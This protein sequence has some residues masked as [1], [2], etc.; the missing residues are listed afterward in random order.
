[1]HWPLPTPLA[2]AMTLR[3]SH[4]H[5]QP[6]GDAGA[7]GAF[8]RSWTLW[9]HEQVARSGNVPVAG[10]DSW[11][12]AR[13]VGCRGDRG[14]ARAESC[15]GVKRPD[16][17]RR[18]RFGPD[19]GRCA[20]RYRATTSVTRTV[21]GAPR[22]GSRRTSGESATARPPAAVGVRCGHG[23]SQIMSTPANR[24]RAHWGPAIL[25]A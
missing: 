24:K 17:S 22:P 15:G 1:M 20:S 10:Y 13:T 16:L 7:P 21:A 8:H 6:Q 2:V 5:S 9:L 25:T 23:T 18:A 14:G 11:L 12:N 4:I 3:W 19:E